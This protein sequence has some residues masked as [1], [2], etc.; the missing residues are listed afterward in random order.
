MKLLVVEDEPQIR[1]TLEGRL[2]KEGFDV[3]ATGLGVE[4]Q[5]LAAANEYDLIVLD[6]MLPDRNGT[7]V[8]RNLRNRGD[9]TPVIMLTALSATGE[10]VA[11]LESGAD[12]YLTKPFEFAE[13]LA[14]VRAILR[15]NQTAAAVAVTTRCKVSASGTGGPRSAMTGP[16]ADPADQFLG[17]RPVAGRVG[18]LVLDAVPRV[19]AQVV[20]RLRGLEAVADRP[21]RILRPGRGHRRGGQGRDAHQQAEGRPSS[22]RTHWARD[23]RVCGPIP[24]PGDH[25]A[26]ARSLPRPPP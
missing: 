3:D 19:P 2:R 4:G 17:P 16:A 11:G 8:C 23:L 21:R 20:D 9:T 22:T 26:T 25:D 14:R 13:L 5:D 15:R 6:V 1:E 12:D 7:D 10:K 18:V 24:T